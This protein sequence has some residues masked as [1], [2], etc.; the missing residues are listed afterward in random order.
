MHVIV[1][2]I[3]FLQKW[4]ISN[5]NTE[6]SKYYIVKST[7]NLFHYYTQYISWSYI[8]RLMPCFED[9]WPFFALHHG[10]QLFEFVFIYGFSVHSWYAQIP[11]FC[12]VVPKTEC[13]VPTTNVKIK[14]EIVI[15]MISK[16]SISFWVWHSCIDVF[17]S[18]YDGHNCRESC[19]KRWSFLRFRY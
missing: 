11:E 14:I 8:V 5:P 12:L 4:L 7:D 16:R 13:K 9:L 6:S 2:Q 19:P 17:N 3:F 18:S 15:L 10:F 1:N